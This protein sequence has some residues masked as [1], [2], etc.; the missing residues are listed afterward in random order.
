MPVSSRKAARRSQSRGRLGPWVPHWVHPSPFPFQS[1]RFAPAGH[2]APSCGRSRGVRSSGNRRAEGR[3]RHRSARNAGDG[4]RTQ[5]A[6]RSGIGEIA[7]GGSPVELDERHE[8]GHVAFGDI[9]EE[10]GGLPPAHGTPRS[11]A[12][13]NRTC[14]PHLF[15]RNREPRGF[16]GGAEAQREAVPA[17]LGTTG[18]R[19]RGPCSCALGKRPEQDQRRPVTGLGLDQRLHGAERTTDELLRRGRDALSASSAGV[20]GGRPDA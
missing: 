18:R 19:W 16:T 1:G 3:F 7:V 17:P 9:A 10:I 6:E 11:K 13:R 15:D 4:L 8:V 5:S 2:H 12:A 20:S 14:S